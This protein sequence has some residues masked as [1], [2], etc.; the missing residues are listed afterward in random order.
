[1]FDLETKYRRICY[2]FVFI[3]GGILTGNVGLAIYGANEAINASI[4]SLE[5]REIAITNTVK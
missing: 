1:M 3:L 4:H 2:A 5:N